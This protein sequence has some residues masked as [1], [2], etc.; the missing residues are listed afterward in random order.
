MTLAAAPFLSP[1]AQSTD[2]PPALGYFPP[3]WVMWLNALTAT[4]NA[5]AAASGVLP[6][7]VAVGSV[8]LSGGVGLPATWGNVL[9]GPFSAQSLSVTGSVIPADGMYLPTTDTLAFATAGTLRLQIDNLGN[10]ASAGPITAP[11]FIGNVPVTDLAGGSGASSTTFWRGD[12]AWSTID[13]ATADVVGLLPAIR[14]GTGLGAYATGDLLYASS[15]SAL[16]RLADVATGNVLRAGGVGV[17]P[18]WG[19]V[20]LTTDVSGTLP[21]GNGGTGLAVY[22][23]G[24][25]LYASGTGTLSRLADVAAG[26]FLRSGGISAAPAWSAVTLPNAATTGDLLYASAT[27]TWASLADV[28]TTNVLKSGGVGVAPA[29]GKVAL[30]SDVSGNLPVTNL[31]SGAS[32]SNTTFWRGDGQWVTPGG[33]G[34][35]TNTGGALTLNHV[36][37]GAGGSDSKVDAV[38]TLSAGALSGITDLTTTGNTIL[39]NATADT[40]NVGNG[41]L[42]KDSGNYFGI[43]C[44]PIAGVSLR[45]QDPTSNDIGWEWQRTSA[46]G[47]TILSYNRAGGVYTNLVQDALSHTLRISGT[48]AF[49]INS[50]GNVGIR[51]TPHAWA[52]GLVGLEIGN[53]SPSGLYLGAANATG[54]MSNN[55]FGDAVGFNRV[56]AATQSHIYQQTASGGQIWYMDAAGAA[57]NYTPTTRMTL[58]AT[59]LTVTLP[60]TTKGYTVAAL[61]AGVLGM[62]AHVTDALAPAFLTAVVGGGAAKS[63][64]FYNGAAWVAA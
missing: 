8:L 6:A 63:L 43:N 13:L 3:P 12:G 15:G 4:V 41:G 49:S 38:A 61:P 1:S 14:G 64:V 50:S 46:S 40:L 59:S 45:I 27:N 47:G 19:Q 23:V 54:F 33:S 44:T 20:V 62:I 17:A 48:D 7:D 39:G 25:L 32:A 60:I 9:A 28:A 34:T 57:G 56:S 51:V 55:V 18:A 10:V 37:V 53:G 5:N 35:V 52:G 30:A 26:A 24:D 16:S 58:D 42:I 11:T 2:T 29:W 31:N 22:A 21:V 36:M